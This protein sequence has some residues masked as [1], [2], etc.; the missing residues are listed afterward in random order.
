MLVRK[1][2]LAS[3]AMPFKRK[4]NSGGMLSPVRQGLVAR[5]GEL[6]VIQLA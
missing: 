3:K 1:R 6:A 4:L 2:L 5:L